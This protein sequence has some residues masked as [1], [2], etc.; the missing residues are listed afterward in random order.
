MCA[1]LSTSTV[2]HF[3]SDASFGAVSP[4]TYIV[5]DRSLVWCRVKLDASKVE[6]TEELRKDREGRQ[7]RRSHFTGLQAAVLGDLVHF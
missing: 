2:Q 1:I 3:V 7:I 4:C 6:P 5:R